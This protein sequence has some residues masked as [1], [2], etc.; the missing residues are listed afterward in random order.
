VQRQTVTAAAATPMDDMARRLESAG[1]S[2][3]RPSDGS[4]I[5]R[6]SQPSV[7]LDTV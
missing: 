1:W 3:D 4:I 5:L 7:E 6:F 2:I